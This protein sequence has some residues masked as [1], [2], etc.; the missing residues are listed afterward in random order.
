MHLR[1]HHK[2][3]KRKEEQEDYLYGLDRSVHWQDINPEDYNYSK[4][5]SR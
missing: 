1:D 4:H 5:Q 3:D 2:T